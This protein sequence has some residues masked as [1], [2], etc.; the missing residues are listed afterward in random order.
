MKRD[1]NKKGF[2]DITPASST[3]KEEE[4]KSIKASLLMIGR[5]NISVKGTVFVLSV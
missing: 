5:I 2:H 1:D 3:L 4:V